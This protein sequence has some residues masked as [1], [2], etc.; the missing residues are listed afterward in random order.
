MVKSLKKSNKHEP[1][2]SDVMDA[3]QKFSGRFDT[4]E[5]SAQDLTEAVQTG[6]AKVEK[7]FDQ[8]DERFNRLERRTGSLENSVEEM[9]ETLDGV[10]RAV[11]KDAV[12]V[13]NYG[14]RIRHLGKAQV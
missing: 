8:V 1:T 6:F 10:A 2:V 13:L 7:R 3:V 9:K 12:T 14:H 5:G 11:D 4:L